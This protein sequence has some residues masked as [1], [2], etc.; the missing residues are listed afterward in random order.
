MSVSIADLKNRQ[1]QSRKKRG[2]KRGNIDVNCNLYKPGYIDIVSIKLLSKYA[3]KCKAIMP[4][5]LVSIKP[6]GTGYTLSV[7]H[8]FGTTRL[9]IIDLE[10]AVRSMFE[11]K[12]EI[13][14]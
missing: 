3:D 10:D 4:T 1:N 5:S 8:S 2:S 11:L 9:H 14:I 6:D 13:S 7:L 12:E